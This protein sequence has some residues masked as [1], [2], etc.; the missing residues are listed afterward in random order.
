MLLAA[1]GR[2]DAR[3]RGGFLPADALT[4][5]PTRFGIMIDCC[6]VLVEKS[7]LPDDFRLSCPTTPAELSAIRC[8]SL[9]LYGD[10]SDILDHGFA[11]GDALPNSELRILE[12]C[13]HA[14]LMEKPDLVAEHVVPWLA[15]PAHQVS[16]AA[17]G[18]SA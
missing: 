5:E 12:G 18:R 7:S 3:W 4:F 8:P 2:D 1:A 16:P 13:T 9:L 11:L 6:E 10:G 14:M 17:T 15:D